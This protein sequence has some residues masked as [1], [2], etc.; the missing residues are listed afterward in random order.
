MEQGNELGT[1]VCY[2]IV[3]AYYRRAA[4]KQQALREILELSDPQA[5]LAKSGWQQA[6]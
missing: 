5:F 1:W 2:R 6:M 4:D 3:N